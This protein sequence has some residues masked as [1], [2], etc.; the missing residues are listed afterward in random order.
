VRVARLAV[1]DP[2]RAEAAA[3]GLR[4]ERGAERE[5]EA[6][7]GARGERPMGALALLADPFERGGRGGD[8]LLVDGQALDRM[9][10]SVSLGDEVAFGARTCAMAASPRT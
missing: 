6:A 3:G 2:A 8:V 10:S 5:L 7:R 1:E 4:G 9:G